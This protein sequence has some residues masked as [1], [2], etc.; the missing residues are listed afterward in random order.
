[1]GH[2]PANVNCHTIRV[3]VTGLETKNF[4]Q[5]KRMERL[6]GQ[7]RPVAGIMNV[8]D[9]LNQVA[10]LLHRVGRCGLAGL[11]GDFDPAG[12]QR[13][14]R[15]EFIFHSSI[16]NLIEYHPGLVPALTY[17]SSAVW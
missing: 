5:T 14:G 16:Q 7:E 17:S 6:Q 9:M 15:D 2:S 12:F 1:M 10:H 3:N 11:T 8:L 13:I 4:L